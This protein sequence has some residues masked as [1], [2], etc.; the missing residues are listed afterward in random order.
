MNLSF[1]CL[2]TLIDCYRTKI[3][4]KV[5]SANQKKKSGSDITSLECRLKHFFFDKLLE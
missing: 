2:V 3:I 1:S 4:K 5:D